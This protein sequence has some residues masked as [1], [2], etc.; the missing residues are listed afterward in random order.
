MSDMAS[1]NRRKRA[2]EIQLPKTKDVENIPPRSPVD[3]VSKRQKTAT[4]PGQTAY[5][6]SKDAEIKHEP[7]PFE[8]H[9]QTARLQPQTGG[10]VEPRTPTGKPV[11]PALPP[12]GRPKL[13]YH[14]ADPAQPN[15]RQPTKDF[16][17]LFDGAI[18]VD[19][20]NAHASDIRRAFPKEWPAAMQIH[21]VVQ[22]LSLSSKERATP[23]FERYLLVCVLALSVQMK[24][25]IITKARNCSDDEC[26]QAL[27]SDEIKHALGAAEILHMLGPLTQ[28]K[29]PR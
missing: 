18:H 22:V 7:S 19:I 29:I 24:V 23:L 12:G 5:T 10:I 4:G 8:H 26:L 15:Q 6:T 2:P 27:Q 11:D 3:P 9:P 1:S 13:T 25:L 14:Q 17:R 20:K 16:N 21:S 28:S